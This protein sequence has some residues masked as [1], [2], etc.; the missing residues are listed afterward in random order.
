VRSGGRP[1]GASAALGK[2]VL[3]AI[4]DFGTAGQRARRRAAASAEPAPRRA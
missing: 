4:S 2:G 1:L 3:R